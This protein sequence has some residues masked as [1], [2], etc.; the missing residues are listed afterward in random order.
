MNDTPRIEMKPSTLD[1]FVR[2][3]SIVMVF[4]YIIFLILAMRS[5]D[6]ERMTTNFALGVLWYLVYILQRRVLVIQTIYN[7]ERMILSRQRIDLVTRDMRL[8]A[9]ERRLDILDSR[10]EANDNRTTDQ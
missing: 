8:T 5:W 2:R 1:T 4:F 9:R 7:Y 3:F 10:E 6:I